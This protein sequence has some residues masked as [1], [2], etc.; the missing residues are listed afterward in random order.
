MS[1]EGEKVESFTSSARLP[2]VL[3]V[4]EAAERLSVGR[5]VMYALVSSGAVES[6]R[7]G[8]LGGYRLTLWSGFWRTCGRGSEAARCD[9]TEAEQRTVVDLSGQ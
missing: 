7:I 4:E 5:T 6:V 9:W 2:L 8:R 1:Y 3:T